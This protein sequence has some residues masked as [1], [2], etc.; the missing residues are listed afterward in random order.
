[1]KILQKRTLK[2]LII[3]L[4]FLLQISCTG[5]N[6]SGINILYVYDITGSFHK[7]SLHDAIS[8]GEKIF[9]A[10]ADIDD[11]TPQVH[12]FSTI[13]E[14]AIK[15]GI[16]CYVETKAIDIMSADYLEQRDNPVNISTCLD[17]IINSKPV[18]ISTDISGAL[19]NASLSLKGESYIG[20]ILFIFSDFKETANL[21]IQSN[22]E[23]IIFFI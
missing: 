7:Y 21:N 11:L 2:I 4:L 6:K 19:L 20:K 23:D 5:N 14:L 1:M 17:E 8:T 12:Q 9:K 22:L 13:S 10:L 15:P 18:M 16:N 3:S